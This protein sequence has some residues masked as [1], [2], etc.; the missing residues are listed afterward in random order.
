[1]LLCMSSAC[2]PGLGQRVLCWMCH[3]RRPNPCPQTAKARSPGQESSSQPHPIPHWASPLGKGLVVFG[4]REVRGEK[5]PELWGCWKQLGAQ[6]GA[7][8]HRGWEAQVPEGKMRR[9]EGSSHGELR[10]E[11]ALSLASCSASQR[12]HPTHWGELRAIYSSQPG[13]AALPADG[14]PSVPTQS[15]LGS[16]PGTGKKRRGERVSGSQQN[17]CSCRTG[18]VGAGRLSEPAV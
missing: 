7:G 17:L 14:P 8:V 9:Q 15:C 16:A 3:G 18:A 2:L 10:S 4:C 12:A 11:S 5:R 6:N 13:R 1:M